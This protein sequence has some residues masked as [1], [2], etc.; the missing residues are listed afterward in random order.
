LA[1]ATIRC[2]GLLGGKAVDAALVAVERVPFTQPPLTQNR[3]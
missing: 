2:S 1:S 3:E